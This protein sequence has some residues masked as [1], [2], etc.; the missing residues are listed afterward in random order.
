M[1]RL[2]L[3]ITGMSCGHCVSRITKALGA[4]D[5]VTVEHVEVGAAKLSYDP[6]K[7]TS[8]RITRA[9]DALGFAA[10]AD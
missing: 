9:V 1:E 6:G 3:S 8:E 5:G 10:R 7:V 2:S 4:L